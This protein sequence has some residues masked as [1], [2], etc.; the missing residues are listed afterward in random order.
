VVYDNAR[1]SDS[2]A[3]V[4]HQL[5]TECVTLVA[6]QFG[7]TLDWSLDSLSALDVVCSRLLADG[8]LSGQRLDLWWKL[9]GCYAGEVVILA[10][11]GSWVTHDQAPGAF[12]I[13]SL[14]VTGFPFG[15]ANR[16]LTGE[17]FK[18]LASFARSLPAISAR[19]QR[20]T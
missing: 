16:I 7:V 15:L 9:I 1:V 12:A 4:L 6:D 10:Y 11:G 20:A 2:D 13:T 19:T 18:S 14:G 17:P 3:E 5:A 8:P